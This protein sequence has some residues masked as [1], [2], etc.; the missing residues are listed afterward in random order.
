MFDYSNM[1]A[2]EVVEDLIKW[3]STVKEID[4]AWTI[5]ARTHKFL[6]I[7]SKLASRFPYHKHRKL[8][9]CVMK[10][11]F[12]RRQKARKQIVRSY[13]LREAALDWLCQDKGSFFVS[14]DGMIGL[15]QP[16]SQRI[17]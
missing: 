14:D 3:I 2:S 17:G 1:P 16:Q 4:Y 12:K 13:I 7:S 6:Y 5:S 15:T 8:R 11:T 9:K 10:R